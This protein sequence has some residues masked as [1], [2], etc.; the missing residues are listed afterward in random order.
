MAIELKN[1][2]VVL[3]FSLFSFLFSLFVFYLFEFVYLFTIIYFQNRDFFY[4]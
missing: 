3:F 2:F 1:E 4:F